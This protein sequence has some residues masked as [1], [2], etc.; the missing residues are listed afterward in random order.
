MSVK[1]VFGCDKKHA[2][3][4]F[5]AANWSDR[6]GHFFEQ[7]A[8]ITTG[9][10]TCT[11]HHAQCRVP[12]GAVIDCMITGMPC[13][14]WSRQRGDKQKVPPK[15]HDGW[16]ATFTDFFE[17]LDSE[18]MSIQG[19]ISEQVMGFADKL[20]QSQDEEA[21]EGH[22][23]PFRLFL[24]KLH[25]RGFHTTTLRVNMTA[26]INEPPRERLY[27]IW[28]SDMLGGKEALQWMEKTYQET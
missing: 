6:V 1:T 27:I 28:V 14:P 20:N 11:L 4:N 16:A 21:L 8:S 9:G 26:W 22:E 12:Q 10:G 25:S 3:Q 7:M 18:I 13:Q 5:V 24:S 15:Q 2:A 23:S 17:I 19:G